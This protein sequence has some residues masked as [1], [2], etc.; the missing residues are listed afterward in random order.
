[1]D[2]E[3]STLAF[4]TAISEIKNTCPGI[5]N[6]FI[7]NDNNQVITQDQNTS[8]EL[9][10]CTAESLAAI[11]KTAA[12]AGGIESLMC[13]GATQKINCTRY[14]NNYF[15]T[16]ASDETDEKAL[17]TIARVMV[18]SMLKLAQE[19]MTSR[20]D[21]IPAT[22][23]TKVP[24]AAHAPTVIATP[25]PAL[26]RTK[27]ITVEV[28]TAEFVVDNLSGINIISGDPDTIQIDR[29]LI[30][31]WKELY[32]D[33]HIEKATV[34]DVA[35]GKRIRCKFQPIKSEKLEG[36]NVVLIPNRIRSKL[37]IKKGAMVRIRP[38]IEDGE[39]KHE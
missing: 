23:K 18:P 2:T 35:T 17:S 26:G 36:Q 20:K 11:M 25:S 32:G 33:K 12:I 37:E 5:S 7:L 9:I 29:A 16:V 30:G 27:P 6:I 15:V 22:P 31:Q 3:T 19:V 39:K 34:E 8:R 21:S 24:A 1:M 28:P 13:S 10:D 14:E 4:R 38:V